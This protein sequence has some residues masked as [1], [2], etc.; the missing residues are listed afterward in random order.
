MC[1][2]TGLILIKERKHWP[3]VTETLLRGVT[4][5]LLQEVLHRPRVSFEDCGGKTESSTLE[6]FGPHYGGA[7]QGIHVIKLKTL[8]KNLG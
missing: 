4:G 2:D 1:V 5:G 7:R 3:F 6:A 8:N